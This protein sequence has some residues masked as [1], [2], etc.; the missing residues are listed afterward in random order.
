MAAEQLPIRN[1]DSRIRL[2]EEC[3]D[4]DGERIDRRE[5]QSRSSWND[6]SIGDEDGRE[7][8]AHIGATGVL[9]FKNLDGVQAGVASAWRRLVPVRARPR[10][11]RMSRARRDGWTRWRVRNN[12]RYRE[13]SH[14][15]VVRH[16]CGGADSLGRLKLR[17]RPQT[18]ISP[19]RPGREIR[20]AGAVI[21]AVACDPRPDAPPPGSYQLGSSPD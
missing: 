21:R 19:D 13:K 8:A 1:G 6:P 2:E 7:K 3:L 18:H 15:L 11:I 10:T 14:R 16:W 9:F 5:I 12:S 20:G 17:R 4:R